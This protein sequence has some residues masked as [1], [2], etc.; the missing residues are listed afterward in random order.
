MF[1]VF[2]FLVSARPALSG[3]AVRCA[4]AVIGTAAGS[5]YDIFQNR[6]VPDRLIYAFLGIAIV[7]LA[8]FY[9]PETALYGIAVAAVI[10]AGGYAAYK[11]G[12]IGEADIYSLAAIALLVPVFPSWAHASLNFPPVFSVVIASCAAFSLYFLQ[13]VIRRC[14]LRGKKPSLEPLVI[15]SVPIYLFAIY[16]MV[17]LGAPGLPYILIISVML[18]STL[19]FSAYKNA[20]M[21]EMSEEVALEKVEEGDFAALES[22]PALAAKHSMR[23]LLDRGEIER[24]KKEGVKAVFVYSKLPPFLPFLLIGLLFAVSYGDLLAFGM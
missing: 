14:V 17:S 10:L 24:L 23:R 1:D 22:M 8:V 12:Y 2:E 15:L 20:V 4:I 5:Y 19:A 13:F 7:C 6:T 16:T 18:V 11:L 21:E 3:E 9:Q